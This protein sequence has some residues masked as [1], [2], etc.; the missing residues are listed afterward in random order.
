MAIS[1][2]NAYEKANSNSI[3][4]Y[5]AGSGSDRVL[6]V[7]VG[8]SSGSSQNVTAVTYGGV[9]MTLYGRQTDPDGWSEATLFYLLNPPSGSNSFA[10]TSSANANAAFLCA[11]LTGADTGSV[12]NGNKASGNSASPGVSVTPTAA[13]SYLVG[14]VTSGTDSTAISSRLSSTI[15]NEIQQSGNYRA[16]MVGLAASS[17]SSHTLGATA[18]NDYWAFV[19]LEIKAASTTQNLSAPHISS[20]AVLLPSQLLLNINPPQ[21][22]P[23]DALYA[24]DVS[25][26]GVNLTMSTTIPSGATLFAPVV[27]PGAVSLSPPQIASTAVVGAPNMS[28]VLAL[29]FIASGASIY[30]P[31]ITLGAYTMQA[32]LISSGL[33]MYLPNVTLGGVTLTNPFLASTAILY[34]PVVARQLNPN[35]L[36]LLGVG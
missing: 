7:V 2:T 27:T 29:G 11:T 1:V 36:L 32:P 24:P 10:V 13:T 21:I 5:N 34:P 22:A 8:I 33:T 28:L 23:T 4:A 6:V 16:G 3:P 26:G 35:E 14:M 19:V 12:G 31:T 9:S 30:A 18:A 25:L 20:A 15:I 17:T